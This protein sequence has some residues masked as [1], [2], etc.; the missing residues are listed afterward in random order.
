MRGLLTAVGFLT[1][2]PVG[3]RA[4]LDAREMARAAVWFPAVGLLIGLL[5][6]GLDHVGRLAW[7]SGVAAALMV[8]SNLVVTGGLH[9]DGL[10]DTADAMFSHRDREGMLAIM[11]DSRAGA[12]GVA[13][14]VSG[15][16]VRFAAYAHLA[17]ADHWRVIALAPAAGRAASVICA[18]AFPYARPAGTGAEVARGTGGWQAAAAVAM[19]GAAGA[20]LLGWRGVGALGVGAAAAVVMGVWVSRRLGGLTGDVYG[21]VNEVVEVAVLLAGGALLSG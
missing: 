18:A 17:G 19:A 14:G 5:L 1:V 13:A 4:S 15:L 10:M 12:L 16:L 20:A 2:A 6:A 7:D 11:K 21:A 3:A 9:V 8:G